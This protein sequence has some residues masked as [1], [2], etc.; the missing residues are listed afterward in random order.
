MF[1]V[2]IVYPAG[3]GH[4][5]Y[6]QHRNRSEWSRRQAQRHAA[7]VRANRTGVRGFLRVEVVAE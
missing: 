3:L 2:R 7:D 4:A 1:S 6:L 5:S